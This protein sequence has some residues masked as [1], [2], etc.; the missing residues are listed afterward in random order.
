M[1]TGLRDLG[2]Q[3]FVSHT[4][5][6]L[7]CVR[8]RCSAA[9]V[10]VHCLRP[11]SSIAF[12]CLCT[13]RWLR[14]SCLGLRKTRAARWD[15]IS[16]FAL[17]F[18]RRHIPSVGLHAG[19]DSARSHPGS[20]A[21]HEEQAEEGTI[22][23]ARERGLDPGPPRLVKPASRARGGRE[24]QP[25]TAEDSTAATSARCRSH[26]TS[27]SGLSSCDC[28]VPTRSPQPCHHGSTA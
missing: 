27:A 6:S 5:K 13:Y 2:R 8:R 19:Y 10:S 23:K 11:S 22:G 18:K 17:R 20:A 26:E 9:A 4:K 1:K 12:G 28:A 25:G 21:D 15:E 14:A 7:P 24:R 3:G 16:L